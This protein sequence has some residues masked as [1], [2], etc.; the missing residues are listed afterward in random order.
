MSLPGV[1][2]I[3][4]TTSLLR[5]FC[6][7]A[8]GQHIDQRQVQDQKAR[9]EVVA[10]IPP[11]SP[12]EEK[13]ARQHDRQAQRN[14]HGTRPNSVASILRGDYA[15]PLNHTTQSRTVGERDNY[16]LVITVDASWNVDQGFD[17]NFS[18]S[19]DLNTYLTDDCPKLWLKYGVCAGPV[20]T[21]TMSIGGMWPTGGMCAGSDYGDFCSAYRFCISID[22]TEKCDGSHGIDHEE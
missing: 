12:L 21:Q 19:H 5:D 22:D 2:P 3:R 14:H 17:L 7:I 8:P 1:T 20:T 10:L 13:R 18:K 11:R 6:E 16:Y 4:G 15:R 9:A